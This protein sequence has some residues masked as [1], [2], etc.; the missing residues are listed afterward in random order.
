TQ[1]S[2]DAYFLYENQSDISPRP[3]LFICVNRG[4]RGWI[5]ICCSSA[6]AV[7]YLPRNYSGPSSVFI[8]DPAW[9]CIHLL[10]KPCLRTR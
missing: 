10:F 4:G 5:A 7:A 8:Q 1:R 6:S 3:A 9:I 2:H